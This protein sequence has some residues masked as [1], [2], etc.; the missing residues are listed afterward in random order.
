VPDNVDLA[1]GTLMDEHPAPVL[2]VQRDRPREAG[3]A[4]ASRRL[5]GG[6]GG[7]VGCRL[8]IGDDEIEWDNSG[9]AQ[10]LQMRLNNVVVL[11]TKARSNDIVLLDGRNVR[12]CQT[13][14]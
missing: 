14:K 13:S 9:C 12:V 5:H 10:L 4:K 7:V 11:G 1:H 3:L 8:D 6:S 2:A